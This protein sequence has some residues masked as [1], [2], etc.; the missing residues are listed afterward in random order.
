MAGAFTAG[1]EVD[2]LVQ[3]FYVQ[4]FW[5]SWLWGWLVV[6]GDVVDN[7]FTLAWAL[8]QVAPP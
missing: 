2:A 5:L 6:D 1:V 7:I 3:A 4:S 8:P